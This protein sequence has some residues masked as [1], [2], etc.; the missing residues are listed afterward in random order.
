MSMAISFSS[1]PRAS[2]GRTI[3]RSTVSLELYTAIMIWS[4]HTIVL[5]ACRVLGASFTRMV[6]TTLEIC[7]TISKMDLVKFTELMALTTKATSKK[8]NFDWW[9]MGT[10]A[11]ADA[12]AAHAP[13]LSS[14]LPSPV[15]HQHRPQ[16]SRRC[17][18]NCRQSCKPRI[19]HNYEIRLKSHRI[20]TILIKIWFL[21][22]WSFYIDS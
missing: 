13:G 9:M 7:W 20:P 17:M 12:W 19:D 22:F 5:T 2:L 10:L 21:N 16:R 11:I 3:Y 1:N 6:T 18:A 4:K 8:D 15:V 14:A